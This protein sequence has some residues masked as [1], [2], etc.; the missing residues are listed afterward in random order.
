M[1]HRN[2]LQTAPLAIALLVSLCIPGSGATPASFDQKTEN[3]FVGRYGETIA[4]R[5]DMRVHPHMDG[6]VEVVEFYTPWGRFEKNHPLFDPTQAK[7]GPE[8]FSRETLFQL[9]VLPL[10]DS[11]FRNLDELRAA[12]ELELRTAGVAYRIFE[13]PDSLGSWTQGTFEVETSTPYRLTQI[14]TQTEG[15]R[16]ILTAGID[17]PGSDFLDSDYRPIRNSL[18]DFVVA[19]TLKRGEE[20]AAARPAARN[21]SR[22]LLLTW[23][24]LQ[25]SVLIVAGVLLLA[26]RA[27]RFRWSLI[28][29]LLVSNFAAVVAWCLAMAL[30]RSAWDEYWSWPTTGAIIATAPFLWL[31]GKGLGRP[32]RSR[33]AVAVCVLYGTL[34]TLYGIS[35][36]KISASEFAEFLASLPAWSLILT[37]TFAIPLGFIWGFSSSKNGS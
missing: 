9:I 30:S 24:V 31:L 13:G 10:A 23:S 1:N 12:K 22:W 8:T 35:N 37:G 5:N 32:F 15:Y 36:G 28:G 19:S 6:S 26:D 7:I 17:A 27:A 21:V 16:F 34:L 33:T 29:T 25:G 14:Y 18:N 20:K 11:G 3:L 4:Y 2:K